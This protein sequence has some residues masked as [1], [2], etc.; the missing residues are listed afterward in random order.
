MLRSHVYSLVYSFPVPVLQPH[1]DHFLDENSTLLNSF[2]IH[3]KFISATRESLR[4]VKQIRVL[5]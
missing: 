3:A 5:V 2:H 1:F 4:L